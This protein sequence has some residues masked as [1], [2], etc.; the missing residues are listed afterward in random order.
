[1]EIA[2]PARAGNGGL[3]TT[4]SAKSRRPRKAKSTVSKS[5]ES[6]RSGES[7]NPLPLAQGSP[8]RGELN[9]V[10]GTSTKGNSPRG[11]RNTK[12]TR[13]DKTRTRPEGDASNH[14]DTESVESVNRRK[15]GKKWKTRSRPARASSSPLSKKLKVVVRRLPPNLPEHV[16]WQAVQP[17]VPFPVPTDSTASRTV[18]IGKQGEEWASVPETKIATPSE[19][20]DPEPLSPHTKTESGTTPD[21]SSQ[22]TAPVDTATV[23]RTVRIPPTLASAEV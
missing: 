15:P 5:L 6:A 13:S 7:T 19:P 22:N 20:A 16:F 4:G 10:S 17:F 23:T 8:I 3:A 1:M 9:G 11:K 12:S 21:I 14:P 18:T 2:L